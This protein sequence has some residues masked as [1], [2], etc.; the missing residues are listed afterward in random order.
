M[1]T[2]TGEASPTPPQRLISTASSRRG[3]ADT[4]PELRPFGRIAY[5]YMH[6][7]RKTERMW[8]SHLLGDKRAEARR[9]DAERQRPTR[10][11]LVRSEFDQF[12]QLKLPNLKPA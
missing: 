7:K 3:Y 9:T 1:L 4:C 12:L 8:L 5:K 6:F 2:P 10:E 11:L